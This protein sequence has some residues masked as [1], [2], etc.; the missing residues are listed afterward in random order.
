MKKNNLDILTYIKNKQS[1]QYNDLVQSE[2][3][4]L[5]YYLIFPFFLSLFI[6]MSL[7]ISLLISGFTIS[8]FVSH[9]NQILIQNSIYS[10]QGIIYC[11]SIFSLTFFIFNAFYKYLMPLIIQFGYKIMGITEIDTTA[12]SFIHKG[13]IEEIFELSHER[14]ILFKRNFYEIKENI[15]TH[16]GLSLELINKYIK[17]I[18][19]AKENPVKISV[20]SSD[21]LFNEFVFT[22]IEIALMDA[23]TKVGTLLNELK[24]IVKTK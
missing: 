6:S 24:A 9:E 14:D 13:T 1:L 11:V 21:E 7:M 19:Y 10:F 5:S 3:N 2:I 16:S 23:N 17:K 15:L 20:N 18:Q 22:D 8:F 4:L 12:Y